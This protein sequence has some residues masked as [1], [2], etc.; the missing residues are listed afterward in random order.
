M[1]TCDIDLVE[2]YPT[3]SRNPEVQQRY[4]AMREAGQSHNMA[5][6]LAC[7]T[8]PAAKT[9]TRFSARLGKSEQMP[10]S[11]YRKAKAAGV[12]TLNKKYMSQLAEYPGDPKAWVGGDARSEITRRCKEKGWGCEGAIEIPT[13]THEI[14]DDVP[15]RVADKVVEKAVMQRALIEPGAVSTPEKLPRVREDT[16]E[17]LTGNGPF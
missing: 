16:R 4:E 15:Y 5:E 13:P 7:R 8:L 1:S 10:A 6:M 17:R 12:S 2:Q 3:V 11:Y 14:P 9:D